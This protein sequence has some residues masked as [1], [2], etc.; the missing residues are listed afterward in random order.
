LEFP[1]GIK[2][3][4]NSNGILTQRYSS[5]LLKSFA[6]S[7]QMAKVQPEGNLVPAQVLL[8]QLQAFP[9]KTLSV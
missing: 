6:E 9:F 5:N 1:N 8:F 4:K 3:W 7:C 2:S